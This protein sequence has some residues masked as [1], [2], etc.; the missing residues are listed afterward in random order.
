MRWPV[1]PHAVRLITQLARQAAQRTAG[2]GVGSE[3]LIRSR[4]AARLSATLLRGVAQVYL[5]ALPG[6]THSGKPW[7]EAGLT[8]LESLEHQIPEGPSAYELW[9]A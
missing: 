7:A 6:L 3:A 1:A 5:D 4:W 8:G 9:I 2:W